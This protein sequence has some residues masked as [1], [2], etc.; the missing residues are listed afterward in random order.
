MVLSQ[1]CTDDAVNRLFDYSKCV[2]DQICS[3]EERPKKLKEIQYLIFAGMI[4]YYGFG[5]IDN[6][7][8]AFKRNKFF[9]TKEKMLD[10]LSKQKYIS[11]ESLS[12][13]DKDTCAFFYQQYLYKKATNEYFSKGKIVVSDNNN[14]AVDDLIEYTVHEVNHA[15][16]SIKK[17]ITSVG[18][19]FVTRTGVYS[20]NFSD[21]SKKNQL[22]EE[23]FNVLQTAEIMD[24]ILNFTNYKINDKEIKYVLDSINYAANKKRKGLGYFE[25]TPIVRPLYENGK[26]NLILN[27]NRMD[28]EI[29]FISAEFDSKV[30]KGSFDNLGRQ[31]DEYY[32]GSLLSGKK[33]NVLI[34]E[35]VSKK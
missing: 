16:N 18:N 32:R 17:A 8:M 25:I 4:S 19:S 22:L 13:M 34:K 5:Q 26:F 20:K 35:Y 7:T 12:S 30:G 33:A 10:Y 27:K 11:Q 2:V 29:D 24:H 28:G 1:F 6:I 14:T 15:V 21:S 23:S 31:I 3:D 9:Y